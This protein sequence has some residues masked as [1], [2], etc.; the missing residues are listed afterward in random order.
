MTETLRA[1]K[2]RNNLRLEGDK[3]V[4]DRKRN[5]LTLIAKYLQDNGYIESSQRVQSEAGISLNRYDAADNVD[6]LGMMIDYED[7]YRIKFGKSVKLVRKVTDSDSN[8]NSNTTHKTSKTTAS[9]K[10]AKEE[11]RKRR[12]DRNN[13][14]GH[15]GRGGVDGQTS[16]A[17]MGK[18]TGTHSQQQNAQHPRPPATT[19]SETPFEIHNSNSNSGS[20]KEDN[21][22]NVSGNRVGLSSGPASSS[23][24]G[25][26]GSRHSTSSVRAEQEHER[27]LLK[28]LPYT[29]PDSRALAGAITRDIYRHNPGVTW[30]DIVELKTAKRLL[31][32]AVVMPILYPELFTGLLAPWKGVLLFG[33]PGTGKTMLARAVATE[34]DTTFF[35]ISA[36]SIVSKYR[37][38]S[39]KLVRILFELARYHAPS[40]VF[41][42]EIDSVMSKRGTGGEH[43]ASR[44]MKTELLIQMDGLARCDDLV[45]VLAASNIPWSLDGAML[46]RLEKR[47]MVSLPVTKAREAMF[48][49]ML[50][51]PSNTA[52][53][54]GKEVEERSLCEESNANNNSGKEDKEGEE[55]DGCEGKEHSSTTSSATGSATGSPTKVYRT[56]GMGSLTVDATLDYKAL[57]ERSNGYSGADIRLIVK[58]AAMRPL[59]RMMQTMEDIDLL[60]Q[61]PKTTN[62]DTLMAK[63]GPITVDDMNAAMK[64]TKPSSGFKVEL[65]VQWNEEFGSSL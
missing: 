33:P 25:G 2:A 14:T 16:T 10:R 26:G 18:L 11:S 53:E 29:D 30:E 24:A 3:K 51:R 20:H 17:L 7:A 62:A 57:A 49:K 64:C 36:S 23:L 40:T 59:R 42:D 48:R 12:E 31:K 65:Y 8:S 44:R 21:A 5:L 60:S 35:N 52:V 19:T 6:L 4:V 27:R 54:R 38:D 43:E 46:R 15:V 37:G 9:Q 50:G 28:P 22:M 34:C 61:N 32:E 63:I 45:F 39:E 41:L 13:Y 56:G 55:E 58:E 1:L 47:I